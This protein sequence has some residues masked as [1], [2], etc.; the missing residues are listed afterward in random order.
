VAACDRFIHLDLLSQE[1]Q[2]PAQRASQDEE[3]TP[4]LP[5]LQR[6][7]STA[8]SSTSEDDGWSNVGEVGSYLVKSHAAFDPRD[9]G[10]SKLGELVRAQPYVDVKDVRGPTG[11]SRLWV[12]LKPTAAKTA[13]SS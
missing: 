4:L 7:L 11:L 8:I 5:N 2:G 12:P 1:P 9:Y 13:R 6:I 3:P 10:H